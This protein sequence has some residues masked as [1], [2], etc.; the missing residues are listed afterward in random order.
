MSE[1]SVRVSAARIA[2]VLDL[3]PPTAEQ[4][5]VIE[6]PLGAQLV[7]AGAG[8]GKT[9]TMASRVVWL[10]ANGLVRP[11]EVL[12]LTFTRKAARELSERL[13]RRLRRLREV[14]L[15]DATQTTPQTTPG[16]TAGAAGAAGAGP[17]D[18]SDDDQSE[19]PAG[20]PRVMTYHS[21]AGQ[22]VREH[23]LRIGL[24]PDATLLTEAACWQIADEVVRTADPGFADLDHAAST[25]VDAVLTVSGELNEHLV[26]PDRAHDYLEGLAGRLDAL[27]GREGRQALKIGAD[28]AD[29][30]RQR[31]RIYP[32]VLEYRRRLALRGA[33]DFS[34]Q[35]AAA[36]RLAIEIPA[37]RRIER[38][39]VGAVLLDEFQDTSDAQLA[40]LAAIFAPQPVTPQSDVRT[41][42]GPAVELAP[43]RRPIAVTAV[44]DP[45]QSIY[46]WRGASATTLVRFIDRFATP[47]E[48]VP[49]VSL[50]TSWRNDT[51]ILDVANRVADPLRETSAVAV[52]QLR[53]APRAG[54]GVVQVA[55]LLTEDDE[56]E[57]L[58]H[59]AA[60]LWAGADSDGAHP[61][62]A[63]L[64]RAR[65]QFA[66]V[67]A[68][69]HRAG[70]PVEV[71]GVGGL[72]A[73]PEVADLVALLEVVQEP[74][75]GQHLMRLLTGPMVR[76]GAADLDVLWAW[77][78]R[79]AAQ[80]TRS[81]RSVAERAGA[82][83]PPQPGGHTPDRVAAQDHGDGDVERLDPVLADA[84]S[85]PPPEGWLDG[86][87]R[88]LST[89]AQRRVGRVGQVIEELRSMAGLALP[90]LIH[91]AE[92]AIELD[93]EVAADPDRDP[94]WSRAQLDRFADVAEQFEA[95][96][97]R[98][99]LAGFLSWLRAA[100]QR[101]RGLEPAP[102]EPSTYA[103]Q[104]LTVHAAKGLEWDAAIVPGLV[105]GSFPSRSGRVRWQPDSEPAGDDDPGQDHAAQDHSAQDHSAQDHAAQD[106]AVQ[107][108]AGWRYTAHAVKGW[109]SGV[110]ALPYPLRGDAD[111]LPQV[112]WDRIED[113]HDLREEIERVGEAGTDQA[114]AEE[115]RLAY[116]AVTRARHRLLLT[117][118]V[119][120]AT[121]TTPRIT[122][123][124]LREAA[125]LSGT[126]VAGWEPMPPVDRDEVARGADLPS[127]PAHAIDRSA[128]WPREPEG[129]RRRAAELLAARLEAATLGSGGSHD[130]AE[131]DPSGNRRLEMLLAE[132]AE[133]A[134]AQA[135]DPA[136]ARVDI[137][138]LS[139][140][141]LVALAADPQTYHR[142][143]RRPMPT[144]PS[145]AA[146]RGTAFHT[147]VQ[148]QFEAGALLDVDEIRQHQLDLPDQDDRDDRGEGGDGDWSGRN[149]GAD[150]EE[151]IDREL[152]STF[153]ASSWAQRQ[154]SAIE[155]DIE[156]VIGAVPVR[157][158]IDAVFP[159]PDG[160]EV[161][162]DWKTGREP[163]G[164]QARLAALQL[165][166]YRVAYC[167]LTGVE[168][169]RVTGAFYYAGTGA[170]VRPALLEEADLV[171]VISELA[172]G[173]SDLT[174]RT[175]GAERG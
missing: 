85:S 48:P 27:P 62:I 114:L 2:A 54:A 52:P 15:V 65:R 163:S 81:G 59:W 128:P 119:W 134:A 80:L 155:L 93:I 5:A 19:D 11:G 96:A 107:D 14:G 57:Y 108:D 90:D 28:T 164:D 137:D 143:R 42:A 173:P 9:E 35:I 58:A 129:S 32:L 44:G 130:F 126:E 146:R 152:R 169:E 55:R 25:L 153:L 102:I 38:T 51:T 92:R 17:A 151:A 66:P 99:S 98:P 43:G 157:C 165:S 70:L 110:G 49:V 13:A 60:R 168:P 109:L 115:R 53:A 46:A 22:L 127:N 97:D 94:T 138:H 154:P 24:E 10:V 83:V 40:L 56:A 106:H 50:S 162:V 105:D 140:S 30:M 64:C 124:Y 125:T 6:A 89:V 103:V 161:I 113:T 29:V 86:T 121:S 158:R 156:T 100:A 167:R 112:R 7:I 150:R 20:E 69:L 95:G 37:V 88:G 4:V 120:G 3:P 104:V 170:T 122:S 36:A 144:A 132:R 63:V 79:L 175:A 133:W 26:D 16:M 135:A 78:R 68:A 1:G 147:W 116:V 141:R 145:D 174:A 45:N 84:V 73:T 131:V 91:A 39:G 76:L 33:T 123:G 87:G 171:S 67:I 47:V 160:G 139:A 8:S 172:G 77:A 18:P 23:G 74:T 31:A 136:R 148:Q 82:D 75:R 149:R 41:S 71:V 118:P 61:S 101:E 166:A 12:G 34:A 111:G 142:R 159:D 21:Y 72:L 117:A